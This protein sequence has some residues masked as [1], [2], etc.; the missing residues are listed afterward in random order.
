IV[1]R[2]QDDH[3]AAH[4]LSSEAADQLAERDLALVFIAVIPGHQQD[5]WSIAVFDASDRDRNPAIGRAV[6]RIRQPDKAV[7]F[8]VAVEIDFGGETALRA[9][10]QW[11]LCARRSAPFDSMMEGFYAEPMS[12]RTDT[13][14]DAVLL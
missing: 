4:L 12:R 7:L 8:A 13:G 5:S 2:G 3:A 6:H 1:R 14:Q 11:L 10:H 9:G